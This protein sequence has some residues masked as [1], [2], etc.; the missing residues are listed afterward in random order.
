M[1]DRLGHGPGGVRA[2]RPQP[3]E[4]VVGVLARRALR[5]VVGLRPPGAGPAGEDQAAQPVA[6]A[7]GRVGDDRAAGGPAVEDRAVELQSVDEL[8][9]VRTVRGDRHVLEV[10]VG[11]PAP[12]VVDDR[13]RVAIGDQ[14]S[15]DAIPHPA[16]HAPGV[17][18]H[19]RDGASRG[20]ARSRSS[21]R[22]RRPGTAR[23][24]PLLGSL[25]PNRIRARAS[26]A[27]RPAA[28]GKF[29]RLSGRGAAGSRRSRRAARRSCSST[30]R[31]P[32]RGRRRRSRP[33]RPPRLSAKLWASR[34]NS[35]SSQALEMSVRNVP[36]RMRVDAHR[37]A[38]A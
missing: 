33:A 6:Q 4:A 11:A 35:S 10:L 5:E 19:D 25:G 26:R 2:G 34:A 30:R 28:C 13:D 23:G 38:H 32:G 27:A 17:H 7:P 20:G 9:H 21:D 16:G 14:L 18:E 8:R 31:W 29:Q 3:E 15:D 22:L 12:A 37:P 24:A 36:G 1:A